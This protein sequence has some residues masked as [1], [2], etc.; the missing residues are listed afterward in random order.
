MEDAPSPKDV[1]RRGYDVVCADVTSL[2]LDVA[3]LD[4]VVCLYTLIHIPLDE[5]PALIQ[6]FGRWLRPGGWL[7]ATVGYQALAGIEDDWLGC[8]APM[9]W[10]RTDADTYRV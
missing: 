4:A 1:V 6:R 3:S 7:I 9:W 8:G 5:Q 10:S 2:N